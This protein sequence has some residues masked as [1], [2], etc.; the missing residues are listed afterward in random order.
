MVQLSISM[1]IL[2]IF[3][4]F[5]PL[6]IPS[7]PSLISVQN[8]QWITGKGCGNANNPIRFLE[9]VPETLSGFECSF[10]PKRTGSVVFEPQ[11][12]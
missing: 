11:D 3:L 9:K 5:C 8:G 1:F 7:K 10:I 12:G 4:L 2:A 6:A